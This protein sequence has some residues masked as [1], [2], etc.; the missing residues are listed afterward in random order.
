MVELVDTL[1]TL[2]PLAVEA[3][4]REQLVEVVLVLEQLRLVVVTELNHQ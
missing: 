3:V 4:V 2:G 1:A